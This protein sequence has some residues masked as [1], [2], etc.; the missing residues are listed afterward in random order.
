MT[1]R[2]LFLLFILGLA[3]SFGVAAFQT[4]PGYM[5]ADYYFLGGQQLAAGAGFSD[6]VLW[7][8][9]DDP[10]GIPHPSHGYWMPLTSILVA[11][12]IKLAGSSA[13]SSGRIIFIALAGFLPPLT[14]YLAYSINKQRSAA[15]LAGL[16]AAFSSF[17]LPFS[18]TTDTFSLAM[19]LGGLFFLLIGRLMRGKSLWIA[20]GL[21]SVAGLMHLARADGLFWFFVGALGLLIA[22]WRGK[23]NLQ[24]KILPRLAQ[25]FLLLLAGYLLVMAPWM[26]R[27]LRVFDTLLS[28]GGLRTLWLTNYDELFIYPAS[29]L[30]PDRWWANG[31]SANLE[32]RMIALG[33]NI[34]S[35]IAVQGQIFLLPLILAGLWQLR[36]DLR[37]KVGLIAWSIV[38]VTMTIL[39]PFPGVRGGFFHSGA[40]VQPLFWAVAPVGLERFI[41]WGSDKR[42]WRPQQARLIF[43]SGLVLLASGLSATVVWQRVI[44]ENIAKPNWNASNE[45]YS[46]VAAT[47]QALDLRDD[48]PVLVNNPPGFYLASGQPA[49]VIPAGDESDL[50][51]VAGRYQA[52]YLLLERNHPDGLEELFANP[53]G[54][55]GFEYIQ[56]I[57]E[58]HILKV[59]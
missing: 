29:V 9:L 52:R 11:F 20:F 1:L 30:S 13:F 45:G 21:G 2:Q 56:T 19:V 8:Y 38:I 58:I 6:P 49:I 40:A 16:L 4:T 50:F 35:T 54:Q 25:N 43:I 27:N 59:K 15:I 47:L 39:F 42:G 3:I 34:G 24:G 22:F 46:Q 36:A 44:G 28:P 17:Y 37:V 31:L 7:N 55:I 51:A 5:D 48:E 26:V 14:A 12:G 32:D 23:G 10:P 53:I 57:A 18:V 33:Q 41:G